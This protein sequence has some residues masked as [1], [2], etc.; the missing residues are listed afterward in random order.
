MAV[1]THVRPKARLSS[2]L[3]FVPAPVQSGHSVNQLA[4]YTAARSSTNPKTLTPGTPCQRRIVLP[5]EPIFRRR[6]GCSDLWP[7][8]ANESVDSIAIGQVIESSHGEKD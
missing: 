2:T 5:R 3:I 8:L 1:A 4:L 7:S 6:T